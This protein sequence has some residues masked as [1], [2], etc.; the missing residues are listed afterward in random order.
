LV[1]SGGNHSLKLQVTIERYC[2]EPFI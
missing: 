1:S 2:S